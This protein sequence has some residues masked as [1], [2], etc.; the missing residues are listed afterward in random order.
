MTNF[1]LPSVAVRCPIVITA[2]RFHH[3]PLSRSVP[4]VWRHPPKVGTIYLEH[5]EGGCSQFNGMLIS[6]PYRGRGLARVLIAIWASLALSVR[7][8]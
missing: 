7:R 2:T 6:P 1:K 3:S 4:I 5:T 8:Q